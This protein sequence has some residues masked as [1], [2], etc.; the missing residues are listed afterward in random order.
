MEQNQRV[1]KKT[2]KTFNGRPRRD[3][4]L[5][6]FG[7]GNNLLLARLLPQIPDRMAPRVTLANG[8]IVRPIKSGTASGEHLGHEI[9]KEEDDSVG[10]L[11]RVNHSCA[12][13]IDRRG[14][15]TT[16]NKSSIRNDNRFWH[17]FYRSELKKL[18]LRLTTSERE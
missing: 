3:L 13:S 8:S 9:H 10:G 4:E 12:G 15:D 6:I 11:E 2:A 17:Q 18:V 1:L 16:T 5:Y 14:I 7:I